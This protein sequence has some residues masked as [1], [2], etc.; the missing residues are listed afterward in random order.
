MSQTTS[1][2]VF[3][4][5]RWETGKQ[6]TLT[7]FREDNDTIAWF[8]WK[9]GGRERERDRGRGR[10]QGGRTIFSG[11]LVPFLQRTVV[12]SH[13]YSFC[14]LFWLTHKTSG[15]I[16]P[17]FY[18]PSKNHHWVKLSLYAYI[19][20]RALGTGLS[21]D[22]FGGWK[23]WHFETPGNRFESPEGRNSS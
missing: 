13:N 5:Y 12:M 8:F 11:S 14:V 1:R 16:L 3:P 23:C 7:S 4:G 15:M 17:G 20:W 21:V 18:V 2:F 9:E 6:S 22:K 19:S 10:V